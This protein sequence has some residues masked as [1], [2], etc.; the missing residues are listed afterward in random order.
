MPE[1]A[2]YIAEKRVIHYEKC[3]SRIKVIQDLSGLSTPMFKTT[4]INLMLA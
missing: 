4:F 3:E 2:W 1:T